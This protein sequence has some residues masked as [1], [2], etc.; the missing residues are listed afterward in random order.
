VQATL[1][2]GYVKSS[3]LCRVQL[4]NM[5]SP[6]DAKSEEDFEEDLKRDVAEECGKYGAVVAVHV[7][8]NSLGLV[9]IKF[10]AVHAAAKCLQPPPTGLNG[11]FFGGM[12]IIARSI[13]DDQWTF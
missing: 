12:Q 6:E 13:P 3:Y 4:T 9:Y 5:F 11:R 7:D 10:G 1:S 8:T 2:W